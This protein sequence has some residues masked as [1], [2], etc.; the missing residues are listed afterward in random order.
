MVT[1][2]SEQVQKQKVDKEKKESCSSLQEST[3]TLLLIVCL[4]SNLPV[5]ASMDQAMQALLQQSQQIA[6]QVEE[7]ARSL[8]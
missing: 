7:L 5:A 2:C 1:L 4:C 3:Q 8:Q 6:A